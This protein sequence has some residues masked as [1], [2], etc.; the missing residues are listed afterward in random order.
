MSSG[1]I[2]R[3]SLSGISSRLPGFRFRPHNLCKHSGEKKVK[4]KMDQKPKDVTLWMIITRCMCIEQFCS[5]S[6]AHVT[7][8]ETTE[9]ISSTTLPPHQTQLISQDV[10]PPSDILIISSSFPID[11]QL[12]LFAGRTLF[13]FT[14][15]QI[16]LPGTLA[17]DAPNI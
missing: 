4:Y 13:F 10:S 5:E 16:L 7:M 14:K 11:R 12:P 17:Q 2:E 15:R 6:S 9:D 8:V 1:K 3:A